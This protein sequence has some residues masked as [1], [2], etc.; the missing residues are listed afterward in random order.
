MPPASMCLPESGELHRGGPSLQPAGTGTAAKA[1]HTSDPMT[2]SMASD[3]PDIKQAV[4]QPFFAQG[5][6]I[7]SFR[8]GHIVQNPNDYDP[9]R[10]TP[11]R[12]GRRCAALF[13]KPAQTSL[14][15]VYASVTS[16]PTRPAHR[17]RR[18]LQIGFD[19][20]SAAVESLTG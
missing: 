10:P 6:E 11:L 2:N 13:D 12:G 17:L 5:Y 15:R 14:S 20:V 1:A 19:C 9:V 16:P 8:N 18:P 4:S 7:A 3:E